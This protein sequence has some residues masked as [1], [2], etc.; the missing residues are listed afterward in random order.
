MLARAARGRELARA[1]LTN[2]ALCQLFVPHH[3]LLD[4]SARVLTAIVAEKPCAFR[5]ERV[6]AAIRRFSLST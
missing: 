1:L 3:D 5:S 6:L 2:L 4:E